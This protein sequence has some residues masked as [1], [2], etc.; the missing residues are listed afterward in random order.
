MNAHGLLNVAMAIVA[1]AGVT[2]IVGHP[3]SAGII[4]SIGNAFQGSIKSAL[5]SAS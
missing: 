5:G 2:T 3:N 4:S 1:V